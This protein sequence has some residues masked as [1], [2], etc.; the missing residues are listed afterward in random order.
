MRGV[1]VGAERVIQFSI[2]TLIYRATPS[3]GG[4]LSSLSDECVAASHEALEEHQRCMELLRGC[5]NDPAM[6]TKYI[7]WY[8]SPLVDIESM[9]VV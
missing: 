7:H 8:A 3:L 6:L 2:L 9:L 1:Y 5:T 4:S